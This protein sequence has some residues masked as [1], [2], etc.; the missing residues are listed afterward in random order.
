MKIPCDLAAGAFAALGVCAAVWMLAGPSLSR[1]WNTPKPRPVEHVAIETDLEVPEYATPTSAD[2]LPSALDTLA[3][4]LQSAPVQGGAS[5]GVLSAADRAA[6]ARETAAA[7]RPILSGSKDDYLAWL[8][9]SGA[10]HL[11]LDDDSSPAA[12]QFMAVWTHNGS[13][14]VGSPID[15]DKPRIRVRYLNGRGPFEAPEDELLFGHFAAENRFPRLPAEGQRMDAIIE[16][17]VPVMN[18]DKTTGTA[19][20]TMLGFWMA[21]HRPGDPWR[22]WRIALY[23]FERPSRAWVPVF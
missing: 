23:D 16:S 20:N 15:A 5:T 9:A 21:R 14:F 3:A 6:I 22:L 17:I 10:S 7:L 8:R 2:R 12:K 4:A 18:I 19:S 11:L 1:W 13:G